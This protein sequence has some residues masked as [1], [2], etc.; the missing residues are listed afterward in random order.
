MFICKKHESQ[1]SPTM[2]SLM[3]YSWES[4]R[5]CFLEKHWFIYLGSFICLSLSFVISN[6]HTCKQIFW[7]WLYLVNWLLLQLTHNLSVACT[8]WLQSLLVMF[9]VTMVILQI[10]R[11]SV[12]F[13]TSIHANILIC[14]FVSP[15]RMS[16]FII[17]NLCFLIYPLIQLNCLTSAAPIGFS[18]IL[19]GEIRLRVKQTVG[20]T[21]WSLQSFHFCTRKV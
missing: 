10:R 20:C 4:A 7:Q 11:E 9:L 18:W 8:A 2:Q 14:F 6:I 15:Y 3:K 1:W 21:L 12:S 19:W 5:V 17:T 16:S 13:P